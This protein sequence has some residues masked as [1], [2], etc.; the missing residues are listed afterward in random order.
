MTPFAVGFGRPIVVLPER[1]IGVVSVEEMRDVLMHEVAH[2]RRR[3]HLIVLLQ[4]LAR[5]LYWPIVTIHGLIRE[6]GQAREELCDN[7]VLRGRDALSYGETLL[8]LAELSFE[9]RPLRATV[10]ILHWKGALERRIAGLLD[11]RRSTMTGNSRWLACLVALAFIGGGTVAS[12]TRF[13]A[14]E[15][16]QAPAVRQPGSKDTAKQG[17]ADAKP[18]P[19]PKPPARR[20]IVIHAVGPDGKPMAGVNVHR[21]VWTRKPIDARNLDRATD[22]RGEVRFDIPESSYIYRLWASAPGYAPLFA[23]WEE[24]E[25]PEQSLP[26]EFTFRLERGTVIGGVIRNPAGQP[27]RGA[28]VEISLDHSGK[29]EP[30][31]GPDHWLATGNDARTTDAEGRWSLDNVPPGDNVKVRLLLNHRDYISDQKWGDLQDKQGVTMQALRARTATITM[32]RG[33]SVTGT[34]T[35]PDGQPIAGAVVVRGERPYWEWGSQEERTDAR[36]AYR[37][38][39]LPRGPVTITAVAP[40]WMPMQKKVELQPGLEPV[41]FPLEPGKE[42]RIRIVNRLGKPIPGV[43]VQ[44]GKWRGNEALY[45]HRHPNVVDTQI[46]YQSS[47]TGLYQWTWAPDDAVTY[48]FWKEGY[49]TRQAEL[50][51]DGK[52]QTITLQAVLRITGKVTDAATGRPIDRFTAIPVFEFGPS[53]LHVDRQHY[54]VF[55]GGTYTIE[56]NPN[57]TDAAYHVRIEAEGYRTAMSDAFRVGALKPTCDFRLERAPAVQGRVVDAQGKP[58]AGARVYLATASQRFS[59]QGEHENSLSANQKVLSDTQG[60]FLLPRPVRALCHRRDP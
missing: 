39:A 55:S 24:E 11:Q 40:G 38:Q 48:D 14:A 36:G 21:S 33:L 37:L 10:G 54:R 30:R 44:I 56:G 42:L 50:I 26:E 1:M 23:H 34:V 6:L 19:A 60:A 51:A 15:G 32:K 20:S 47:E 12:A 58:V 31:V 2:I 7:H 9:G 13:I 49:A 18:K 53:N 41:D 28:T 57:Q 16:G 43:N 17:E 29:S 27:I 35:D 8:H 46:P 59:S 45:N 4:E 52:E 22:E 25:H 5:A 3:D